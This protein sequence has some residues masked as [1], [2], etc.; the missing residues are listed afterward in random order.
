MDLMK[1]LLSPI[2]GAIGLGVAILYHLVHTQKMR[3][4]LSIQLNLLHNTPIGLVYIQKN[5]ILVNKTI[6]LML[7]V[8]RINR[9][10]AFLDLFP[11]EIQQTLESRCN[12][13]KNDKI[14][15]EETILFQK[16]AFRVRGQMQERGDLILW[17]T[18]MTAPRKKV[19]K[20]N[21]KNEIESRR[22]LKEKL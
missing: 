6:C 20:E 16:R 10:E 21:Q 3:R 22:R 19:L 18:D 13:L 9:W 11:N 17:W 15:F 5:R 4:N 7:G 14:P 1:I 2:C 12:K 8:K